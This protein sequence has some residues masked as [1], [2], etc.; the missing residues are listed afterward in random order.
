MFTEYQLIGFLCIVGTCYKIHL[1]LK[2]QQEI[3]KIIKQYM[4][5]ED[6]PTKST[7]VPV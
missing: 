6:N 5:I 2:R 3:N 1:Y 7:L 4:V